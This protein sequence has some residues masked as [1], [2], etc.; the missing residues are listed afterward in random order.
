MEQEADQE[1][2]ELINMVNETMLTDSREQGNK[3]ETEKTKEDNKEDVWV[4][5][6]TMKHTILHINLDDRRRKF[7]P[8]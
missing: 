7:T 4:A 5:T 8:S 6:H 2:E 3:E 1:Q